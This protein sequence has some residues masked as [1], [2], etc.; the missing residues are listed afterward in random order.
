MKTKDELQDASGGITVPRLLTPRQVSDIL[1]LSVG[2]LAKRRL[3]ADGPAYVKVGGA[4]RYTEESIRNF[5]QGLQVRRSTSE[6][7]RSSD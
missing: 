7:A 6:Q 3:T 1:G 4:V 2:T 5:V